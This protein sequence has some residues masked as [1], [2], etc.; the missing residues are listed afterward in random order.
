MFIYIGDLYRVAPEVFGES[1]GAGSEQSEWFT[2]QSTGLFDAPR[3][4]PGFNLPSEFTNEI[5]I[6]LEILNDLTTVPRGR[7]VT[8]LV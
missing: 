5:I 7:T 8:F 4:S 3:P 6:R 1:S 2:A